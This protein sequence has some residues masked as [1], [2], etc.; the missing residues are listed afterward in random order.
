MGVFMRM[1]LCA[2]LVFFLGMHLGA[3]ALATPAEDY[4]KGMQAF[5]SGQYPLALSHFIAARDGGMNSV[6]LNYNLG[7]TYFRLGRFDEAL[8]QFGAV[9]RHPAWAELAHYNMGLIEEVQKRG[10]AALEH[11]RIAYQVA[12]TTQVGALAAAKLEAL[13]TPATAA[14]D[15]SWAGL[16]SLGAGHDDNVL[17]S[18]S[19]STLGASNRSDRFGELQA[20]ASRYVR[21]G[22][23][24]G[25]RLDLAGYYRAYA[26][27]DDYNLGIA[28]A[29]LQYNRLFTHW[30]LESAGKLEAQA[31][32][33][34]YLATVGSYT[35]QAMHAAGPLILRLRNEL[36]YYEPGP[37]HDFIGGWQNRSAIELS[38]R[39]TRARLRFGYE[40]EANRRKDDAAGSEFTSYSP[41][42][43]RLFADLRHGI[44][45]QLQVYGRVEY[46]WSK[47]LD[48][49]VVLDSSS[50]TFTATR[51]DNRLTGALR[52]TYQPGSH[53]RWFA[54]YQ[55]A[56]NDS[57]F[58]Q[59][60]YTN[61]QVG[62]GMEFTY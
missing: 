17:L 41:V 51:K 8:A 20:Y 34:D 43:H 49:N 1:R 7:S 62:V 32:G 36:S 42:R 58:G 53:W 6:T 27:L 25:W 40:L 54:D 50:A 12:R 23:E 28:S 60:A 11:F 57:N 5:G 44:T 56:E 55:R 16:V 18:D 39:F 13:A 24:A 38:R 14:A 33:S 61:G 45:A 19:Q 46:R 37:R 2:A 4:R 31:S 30:Y 29:N 22:F 9:A 52:L 47:Y 59:Y 26:E 21:G 10:D 48:P 15:S 3:P 35:L